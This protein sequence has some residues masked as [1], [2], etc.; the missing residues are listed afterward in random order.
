MLPNRWAKRLKT[1]ESVQRSLCRMGFLLFAVAPTLFV[2]SS[3][4]WS[5]T[6]WSRYGSVRA[7]ERLISI[8]IGVDVDLQSVE[9]FAPHCYRFQDV[10]LK[11]PETGNTIAIIP[12]IEFQRG[13][14]TWILRLQSPV[15]ELDEASNLAHTIHQRY[16]CQP[17]LAFPTAICSFRGL[18]L[19]KDSPAMEPLHLE[20]RFQCN[21]DKTSLQARFDL[22]SNDGSQ[23]ASFAV[24]RLHDAIAP[25]TSWSLETQGLEIPGKVLTAFQSNASKLGPDASFR[26]DIL[27]EQDDLNWHAEIAGIFQKVQWN[28]GQA[29]EVFA[30]PQNSQN[31]RVEH[32]EIY[33]GHWVKVDGLVTAESGLTTDLSRWLATA[34]APATGVQPASHVVDPFENTAQ[35]RNAPSTIQR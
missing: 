23:S 13:Q 21:K 34:M 24:E 27:C 12:S 2:L 26:G 25:R 32:I 35:F 17:N 20:S 5:I 3:W 22:A 10:T 7:W 8:S 19:M 14:A 31:V 6:P 33:N 18:T 4:L 29:P 30:A 15:I 9:N 11:H 16:L 1:Q 28:H